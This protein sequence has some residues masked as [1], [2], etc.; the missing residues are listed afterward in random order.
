MCII[1]ILVSRKVFEKKRKEHYNEF[2]TAKILAKQM[3]DEENEEDEV[4]DDKE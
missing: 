3:M 4:Y 2:K 1:K